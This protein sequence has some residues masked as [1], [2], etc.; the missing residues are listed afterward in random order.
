MSWQKPDNY[1]WDKKLAAYWHDP[2]DK[3]FNSLK[4][5]DR[6][7]LHKDSIGLPI[8]DKDILRIA[9][10]LAAGFE[11]GLLPNPS[12]STI[13]NGYI[14][15]SA[16]PLLTHPTSG[17]NCFLEIDRAALDADKIVDAFEAFLGSD[18]GFKGYEDAISKQDK[19]KAPMARFYYTHLVLRFLLAQENVGGIAALWH[20]LPADPRFPDHT[21]WQHNAL[22]SAFY[23]SMALFGD[24]DD[25]GLLVFSITPVQSFISKARKLRDYWTGSVILSWLAFEGIR[26]VMENLG[27]DHIVYPSL[28]DQP[29]VGDYLSRHW[30]VNGPRKPALWAKHPAHIASFPNK[31]LFVLPFGQSEAIAKEIKA[32]IRTQWKALSEKVAYHVIDDL[33]NLSKEENEFIHEIFD[34]QTS[35]FWELQWAAARLIGRDDKVEVEG[36]LDEKRWKGPY[37]VVGAF[38]KLMEANKTKEASGRGALYS[39][40]HTLAQSALAAEKALRN[41]QREKEEGEKCQ[42]CGEFEVL[43]ARRWNGDAAT[44]YNNHLKEFWTQLN[45][46]QKSDVD[47]KENERLCSIC[48]IKRMSGRV[49]A[50]APDHILNT[51]FEGAEGFP[52]TAEMALHDYF[53]R[54]HITEKSRK[55]CI[56]KMLFDSDADSVHVE[57]RDKIGNKDKYYAILFMDGDNIG[58]LINGETTAATW[59]S[60]M[61][62]DIVARLQGSSFNSLYRDTWK[63]IWPPR[64][65]LITPAIHA[66]ISEAL[67]DFSIYGVAQIINQHQGRLIY[68]GGDDVC[69]V[70]PADNAYAAADA[71]QKY[72]I[73]V[74]QT[75]DEK[76][77]TTKA[78]STW[79]PTPGKLAVGLGVGD[80]ISISAAILICHHKESLTQMLGRAHDLLQDKA[81]TEAGRNACAIELQ[82]R[83]GGSRSF[84]RKWDSDAWQSFSRLSQVTGG[85]DREVS[86]RLIHRLED[87]RPGIEAIV[88]QAGSATGMVEKFIGSLLEKSYFVGRN[89]EETARDIARVSIGPDNRFN[90]E[91]LIIASFMTGGEYELV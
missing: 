82:K 50:N 2:P 42:M 22:C 4:H 75:I 84:V 7:A 83:H 21:I 36:L 60:A 81:K 43:H 56:A 49:L 91:G 33:K 44:D 20:R 8:I 37:E 86:N 17:R 77:G 65:R 64:R 1:Y 63:E 57:E 24:T 61:H 25:V 67:G 87:L 39:V 6:A 72:Y 16:N 46:A 28:I 32:H 30:S 38:Q 58:K 78:T 53:R 89:P 85:A 14:D 88:K 71:I 48:L 29:L 10:G 76:G 27:P 90:P 18:K 15:F 45:E 52:S 5:D 13:T 73:G 69:A 26:W 35:C 9:D 40:T 31:F 34:R 68:A 55:R 51:V 12:D 47:F 11:R 3:V 23:S 62:R 79:T 70:M 59:E 66:A 74:F 54:N 19:T 41:I 80:G